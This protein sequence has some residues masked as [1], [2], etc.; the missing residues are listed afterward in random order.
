MQITSFF[1]RARGSIDRD[2]E[3]PA[4]E[5]IAAVRDLNQQYIAAAHQ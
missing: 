1:P 3:S 4:A 5:A 2:A